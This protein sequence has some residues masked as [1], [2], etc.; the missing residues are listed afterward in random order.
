MIRICGKKFALKAESRF[1]RKPRVS[2]EVS[3]GVI[4]V[5]LFGQ[6]NEESI[7]KQ[8]RSSSAAASSFFS[9]CGRFNESRLW[10]E[11]KKTGHPQNWGIR[12]G[13]WN[14]EL[15][16]ERVSNRNNASWTNT[17]RNNNV[18]ARACRTHQGKRQRRDK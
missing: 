6:E 7:I 15:S 10:R 11:A 18:G 8:C 13:S 3:I 2:Q 12:G 4:L 5:F 17:N 9:A 16:N 14:N 1:L